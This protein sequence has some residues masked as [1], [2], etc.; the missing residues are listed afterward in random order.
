[1]P[2]VSERAAAGRAAR[3]ATPR[4]THAALEATADRRPLMLLDAQN[5]SRVAELVPIRRERMRASPFAF[6]RGAAVVM[7]HDLAAQPTSGL[8]RA[9]RRGLARRGR[10]SR[11]GREAGEGARPLDGEGVRERRHSGP[12]SADARS[13]GLPRIVSEPPLI[14]PLEELDDGDGTEES[15]RALFESYRRSLPADRRV[16]L[17]RF[18]YVDSARKVIGIGSVGTR[19][20]IVL[21][22]GRDEHDPLLLQVKEAAASVLEPLLGASGLAND[23]QR[24]VEGQRL[25]QA[26]SDIFLG[27]LHSKQDLDGAPRDYY[28]RQLRDWKVS[29][30]VDAVQPEGLSAHAAACAWTLARA[31]A[32][33]GDRI[34]IAAYLGRGDAF[35][36]AVAE[37][38]T[39]YADLNERDHRA[40]A[41]AG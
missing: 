4:S 32:R 41:Q 31:H 28:V 6:F 22:L 15:L 10:Q 19:C 12:L 16:L 7:A 38:A 34:A 37:F 1:M 17:D 29:L 30:K 27:W 3:K 2:S 8:V 24:V 14:V 9:S 36:R 26:A 35:D 21:M 11:A 25:M 18:R 20:W 33:S 39:A 23:G 5:A 13:R 40:F